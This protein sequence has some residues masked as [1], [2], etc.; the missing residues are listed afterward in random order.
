MEGRGAY[1]CTDEMCW[2]TA[3]KRGMLAKQ[4]RIDIPSD[5]IDQLTLQLKSEHECRT[6]V[7][8]R[9]G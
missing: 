2:H 1:V 7:A 3:A 6:A 9:S 4:L 8:V 5:V